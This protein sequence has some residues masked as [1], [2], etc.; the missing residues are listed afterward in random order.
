MNKY[1]LSEMHVVNYI[2]FVYFFFVDNKLLSLSRNIIRY[3][4][5]NWFFERDILKN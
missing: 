3:F 5:S 4:I 2:V 1:K